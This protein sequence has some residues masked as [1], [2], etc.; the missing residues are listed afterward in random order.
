MSEGIRAFARM[1]AVTFATTAALAGCGLTSNAPA[2]PAPGSGQIQHIVFLVKEN[3]TFDNYFGTFPGADG[4]TTGTISTGQVLSLG[5]TPDAIPRDMGHT[6]VAANGAI[7]YGKTD[8]FD[9]ITNGGNCTVNG[10]YL[11]LT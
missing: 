3:R 9:L 10:D 2:P 5:V 8:H 11:C 1:A 4:A 6:W 7:D